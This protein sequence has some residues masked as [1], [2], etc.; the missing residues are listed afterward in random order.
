MFLSVRP[1]AVEDLSAAFFLL[2]DRL[3][4]PVSAKKDLVK[5]WGQVLREADC[6]SELVEDADQRPGE[7]VAA[8]GITF[9]IPQAVMDHA[10]TVAPPYPWRWT[11]ERWKRGQE[12]WLPKKAARQ[13]QI[14]AGSCYLEFGGMD[15]ARYSGTDLANVVNLFTEANIKESSRH[16]VRLYAKEV[17]GSSLR[18]RLMSHGLRVA[19]DFKELAGDPELRDLPPERWPYLMMGDHGQAAQ[20]S[21]L[22]DTALGKA[23]VRNGPQFGFSETEQEAM[24]LALLGLTDQAIAEKLGLTLVAIKKRWE[25]IYAKVEEKSL[26]Q[27]AENAGDD[28][29][30]VKKRRRHVLQMMAEHPEEFWPSQPKKRAAR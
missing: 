19:R 15:Y 28:E 18:D 25:G 30:L 1:T 17:Y 10:L 26:A 23:A 7:R 16:R 27:D 5:M 12:V 21:R 6:I 3:Y 20:D 22:W 13:E 9:S 11:L 4:I 2:K 14:H 8:V 24:K 29:G